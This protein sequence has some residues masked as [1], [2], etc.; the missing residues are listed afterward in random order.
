MVRCLVVSVIG[1]VSFGCHGS[2]SP[3]A[4]DAP[5]TPGDTSSLDGAPADSVVV[6]DGGSGGSCASIQPWCVGQYCLAQPAAPERRPPNGAGPYVGLT[7]RAAGLAGEAWVATAEPNTLGHISSTGLSMVVL[8]GNATGAITGMAAVT[9]SDIYACNSNQAWHYDGVAWS[10]LVDWLPGDLECAALWAGAAD[11]VWRLTSVGGVTRR[12]H[13]TWTTY[14][15]DNSNSVHAMGGSGP[16]DVWFGGRAG[17]IAHWDGSQYQVLA[18]ASSDSDVPDNDAVYVLGPDDIAIGRNRLVNG[19]LKTYQELGYPTQPGVTW[20]TTDDFWITSRQFGVGHPATLWHYAAGTWTQFPHPTDSWIGTGT[21]DEIVGTGPDD[22]WFFW[23][24]SVSHWNGH[25]LEDCASWGVPVPAGTRLRSGSGDYT[26]LWLQT[27]TSL[28]HAV[29]GGDFVPD[30]Y[31]Y[32][33]R[34][35]DARAGVGVV[36]VSGADDIDTVGGNDVKP[37]ARRFDGT[38]WTDITCPY[39]TGADEM[40]LSAKIVAANDVWL[41]GEAG[42]VFHWD[43]SACT[44]VPHALASTSFRVIEALGANDVWL[45]GDS[46]TLHWDGHTL[47]RQAQTISATDAISTATA[48]WV[49]GGGN[50]EMWDGTAWTNKGTGV[51]TGTG[52]IWASSNI[53]VWVRTVGRLVHFDGV[54]WTTEADGVTTAPWHPLGAEPSVVGAT[55]LWGNAAGDFVMATSGALLHHHP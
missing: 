12:L 35:F 7:S 16:S 3:S 4:T 51:V 13:G 8:P 46:A 18:D 41:A 29:N 44:S 23:P 36:A 6:P 37:I 25:T 45:F 19:T 53:D 47:T 34:G 30:Q 17:Y 55:A 26:D 39:T 31:I 38:A 15:T 22:V 50:V 40:L 28:A 32:G 5:S 11:D 48:V 20:G 52:T 9:A 49:V 33:T 10:E 27:N 21:E 2:G 42:T 54:T 43:G 24:H 14:P 1:L